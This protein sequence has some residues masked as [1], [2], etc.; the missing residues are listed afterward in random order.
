MYIMQITISEKI[1]L[2]VII[3]KV[4]SVVVIINVYAY[5]YYKYILEK[6]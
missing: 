5:V 3:I 4:I 6:F 2:W 1:H